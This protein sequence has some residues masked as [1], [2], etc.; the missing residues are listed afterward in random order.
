M[1]ESQIA[2]GNDFE[3][4]S[5]GEVD[6]DGRTGCPLL[7][8]EV[9]SLLGRSHLGVV[10][11]SELSHC[12]VSS[13]VRVEELVGELDDFGDRFQVTLATVVIRV[14]PKD[15]VTVADGAGTEPIL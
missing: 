9:L 15:P 14:Q 3:S 10:D 5:G 8:C 11:I 2:A 4:V 7:I 12:A 1:Q 6:A 13:G